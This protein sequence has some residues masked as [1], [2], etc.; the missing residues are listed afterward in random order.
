MYR[1]GDGDKP[2]MTVWHRGTEQGHLT[3]SQA[4][5]SGEGGR[6]SKGSDVEYV[7]KDM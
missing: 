3:R 6:A 4:T 1:K 5:G 2:V 7:L